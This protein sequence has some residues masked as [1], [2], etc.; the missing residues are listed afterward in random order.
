MLSVLSV[1]VGC[2]MDPRHHLLWAL[3]IKALVD[4]CSVSQPRQLDSWS[5][6][7]E[8]KPRVQHQTLAAQPE[9]RNEGDKDVPRWQLGTS[10]NAEILSFTK[11]NSTTFSR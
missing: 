1:N 11:Q 2:V 4:V 3:L 10:G 7:K 5:Q 6:E 9:A 8:E